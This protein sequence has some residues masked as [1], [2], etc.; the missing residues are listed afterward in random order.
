MD[1][2]EF[3]SAGKTYACCAAVGSSRCRLFVVLWLEEMVT[4]TTRMIKVVIIMMIAIQKKKKKTTSMS[5]LSTFRQYN[6][7]Y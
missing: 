4:V 7:F 5:D 1:I 3:W 2:N 6:N